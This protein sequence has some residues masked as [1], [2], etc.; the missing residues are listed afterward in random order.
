[1]TR[2]YVVPALLL[3]L[4]IMLAVPAL[5]QNQ[6]SLGTGTSISGCTII[7]KPGS[8]LLA[9]NITATKRD[10]KQ[11][12]ADRMP[13]C[14]VI[15]SD[16]VSLDLQG[17]TIKGPGAGANSGIGIYVAADEYGWGRF[18]TRIRN[19][20]VTEFNPGLSVVAIPLSRCACIITVQVSCFPARVIRSRMRS[21]I[22]TALA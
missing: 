18:E 7:D 16:F 8:Y 17:Y 2:R 5:A 3:T 22:L 20:V 15:A 10:L 13:G 12:A 9:K 14:I 1:M 19:G 6:S 4:V 21:C 11:I